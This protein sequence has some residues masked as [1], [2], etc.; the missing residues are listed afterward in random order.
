M[1]KKSFIIPQLLAIL[2]F[3]LPL[4]AAQAATVSLNPEAT[5]LN[6][7]DI[8]SLD[9]SIDLS[10]PNENTTGGAIDIRWDSSIIQ[11]NNNFTFDSGVMG[12]IND[13]SSP[14]IRDTAFD[15]IDFQSPGLLSI[16]FGNFAG[17]N[18]VGLV[19]SI[20]FTV[21]GNG[22]TNVSLANSLKWAGFFTTSTGVEIN[23]VFTNATV[24]TVP[25]PASV[26]LMISG[27]ITVFGFNA[28]KQTL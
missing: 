13:T 1:K 6:L 21:I 3:V 10:N 27:L 17:I 25:L 4:S 11:Y 20:E 16:G 18:P 22:T 28:R 24:S 5:S 8:F 14:N 12:D 2:C 26:W 9:F 7:N 19:G 23:P 15:V